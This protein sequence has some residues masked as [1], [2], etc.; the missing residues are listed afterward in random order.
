MCGVFQKI[1]YVSFGVILMG[2]VIFSGCSNVGTQK[3]PDSGK[4]DISA[5]NE[6]V[7]ESVTKIR[8]TTD[9]IRDDA[10]QI[11]KKTPSNAKAAIS[12]HTSSILQQTTIQDEVV[13]KLHDA[14]IRLLT[15]EKKVDEFESRYLIID[16][17]RQEAQDKANQALK[18]RYT[19]ISILCFIGL[20]VCLGLLTT[21]NKLAI[22]GAIICGAGCGGSLFIV[23][24]YE[25]IAL[26]VGGLITAAVGLA[27]WQII[28]KNRKIESLD[29]TVDE[30]IKTV[31]A[32][33]PQ[34]TMKSRKDFFGDGPMPGTVQH[35]QSAETRQI[36]N[37]KRSEM[38]DNEKAPSV[39][40]TVSIDYNGDGVIDEKDAALSDMFLD[41]T[42]QDEDI[43]TPDPL[44]PPA[45][46]KGFGGKRKIGG[47]T[48]KAY[49]VL[50]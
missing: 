7:G 49:I 37:D 21:G 42:M 48:M 34:L 8:S 36:V 14:N 22:T 38:P 30:Q 41:D 31:E 46:S 39:P 40:A 9:T 18:D 24:Q 13:T 5:S 32:L 43:D 26:G 20:I 47:I 45:I 44:D 2:S 19:S 23:K 28:Q 27:V 29:T 1:V 16:K 17:Q 10:Q 15:A 11:N 50:N 35:I 3:L 6:I 12:P 4:N 33:K 25:H